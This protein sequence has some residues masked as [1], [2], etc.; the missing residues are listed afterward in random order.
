M[1][2]D[3]IRDLVAAWRTLDASDIEDKCQQQSDL[4]ENYSWEQRYWITYAAFMCIEGKPIKEN[5]VI[6]FVRNR[7]MET[8]SPKTLS[9]EADAASV[10]AFREREFLLRPTW[11]RDP[12]PGDTGDVLQ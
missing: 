3:E 11:R 12:Q 8:P 5:R 9:S 1:N 6:C 2:A 4:W 7:Y 10:S